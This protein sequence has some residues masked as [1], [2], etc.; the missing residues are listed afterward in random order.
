MPRFTGISHVELTVTDPDLTAEWW[1]RVLRFR[2]VHQ[3]QQD[4]FGGIAMLHPSGV[5]VNVL[6]HSTSG[7]DRFDERRVGL[8][9]LSFA[10]AS[11]EE[12]EAWTE[13]LDACGVEH[14]GII[15]AHFGPTVVFR[16]PDN[17]QLELFAQ[18][19]DAI[20]RIASDPAHIDT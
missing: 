3:F 17:I 8:D 13:H 19:P 20:D 18:A 10:V 6:S 9:H 2:R 11:P 14:S 15:D 5:S 1:E 12:M 4:G 7:S 16:D